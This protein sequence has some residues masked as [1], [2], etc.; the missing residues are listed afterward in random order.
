MRICGAV[1]GTGGAF[2]LRCRDELEEFETDTDFSELY[3][4]FRG[5]SGGAGF[6]FGGE[7]SKC[8]RGG[9]GCIGMVWTMGSEACLSVEAFPFI[10]G[11]ALAIFF[12]R[13]T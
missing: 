3:E 6:E 10:A 8:M 2:G 1:R 9:G 13:G 7:D 11:R 5:G 12:W 4:A